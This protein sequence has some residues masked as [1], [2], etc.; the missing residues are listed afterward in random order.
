[1]LEL[2]PLVCQKEGIEIEDGSIEQTVNQ[3]EIIILIQKALIDQQDVEKV[4]AEQSGKG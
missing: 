3:T 4:E 1:M 2:S